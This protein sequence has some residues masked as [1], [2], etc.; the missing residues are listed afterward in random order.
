MGKIQLAIDAGN[1]MVKIEIHNG[2]D[3]IASVKSPSI[4]LQELQNIIHRYKP[5]AAILASVRKQKT[6]LVNAL[7]E[8]NTYIELKHTTPLPISL[9]Y[10]SPETLGLD[11]LAAAV[12]AH[13]LFPAKNV[14]IIDAGTCITIDL[15]TEDGIYEGGSILP[16]IDMK[17]KALHNYTDKLPLLM[18]PVEIPLSG[19]NSKTSIQSGIMHG[20]LL[21]IEGFIDFYSSSFPDL[22]VIITGGDSKLFETTLKSKIFAYPKLVAIGLIKILE[23]NDVKA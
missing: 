15:L 16:G 5:E 18:R 19:K 11:R 23:H 1:T 21:E 9:H 4:S 13:S 6:E 20:T 12:G 10:E 3:F 14:L 7:K 22:Q 2:H 8:L 17:F